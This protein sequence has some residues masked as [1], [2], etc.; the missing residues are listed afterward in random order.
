MHWGYSD[1][2]KMRVSRIK[3]L[4]KMAIERYKPA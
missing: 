2:E 1:L 3:R 4:H